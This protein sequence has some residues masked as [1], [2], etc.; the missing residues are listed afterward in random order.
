MTMDPKTGNIMGTDTMGKPIIMA[1]SSWLN[2]NGWNS[3]P[4]I[5][6]LDTVQSQAQRL[7]PTA[8]WGAE[9]LMELFV[10]LVELEVASVETD[11]DTKAPIVTAT[12]AVRPALPT[13]GYAAKPSADLV[14]GSEQS[15]LL[16]VRL[17]K[18]DGGTEER[19]LLA[20]PAR[21]KGGEIAISLEDCTN[22]GGLHDIIFPKE[23]ATPAYS[24]IEYAVGLDMGGVLVR[25]DY[26][27]DTGI[28]GTWDVQSTFDD[29]VIPPELLDTTGMGEEEA[30]VYVETIKAAYGGGMLGQTF[31]SVSVITVNGKDYILTPQYDEKTAGAMA[32][33]GYSMD[34]PTTLVGDTMRA[35]SKLSAGGG[36]TTSVIETEVSTDRTSMDGTFETKMIAPTGQGSITV[37]Y[38]GTWKATR[39]P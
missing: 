16:L 15:V 22:E 24:K 2:A 39:R 4:G 12:I 3:Y 30:K 36:S 21:V 5:V 20:P 7:I 29:V 17:T 25:S 35:T 1:H 19:M 9:R 13:G 38:R 33:A 28:A 27:S 10:P 11:A 37:V 34:M 31:Q 14:D 32:A 23:G 8:T 18:K 6:N 26:F